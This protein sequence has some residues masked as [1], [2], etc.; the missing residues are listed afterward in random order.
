MEVN[1]KIRS[2]KLNLTVDLTAMVSVSFL[3]IIFFMVNRELAKPNA[4]PLSL[5]HPFDSDVYENIGCYNPDENRII[6]LLLDN[7]NKIISYHGLINFP[8]SAPKKLNF[9]KDIRDEI[10]LKNNQIKEYMTRKG[11]P[12]MGAIFII[13][14]TNKSNFKNLV[15]ILNEMA[16]ANIK[17]YSIINDFIPEEKALLAY[18]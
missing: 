14:P 17:S 2:K 6:T 18:N 13:K 15:D 9:G 11:R 12:D 8:I 1:R 4:L 7:N 10:N 16:I 3:L 5:P